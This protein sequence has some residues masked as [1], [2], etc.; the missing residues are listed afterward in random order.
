MSDHDPL[1]EFNDE[2]LSA[3][4]DDE[5]TR[6]ER[7]RVEERLAVDPAARQMLDQLRAVSQAVKDLPQESVG[8]DL[9]EAILQRATLASADAKAELRETVPEAERPRLT[10]G[11]TAR[12]WVWAGLAVAAALL[13]MIYQPGS[14]DKADLPHGGVAMRAERGLGE[15]E[16][17]LEF[18]DAGEPRG[19]REEAAA[20][21]ADSLA[22]ARSA[23][24][25][26]EPATAPPS[27][28]SASMESLA[29]ADSSAVTDE[30]SRRADSAEL[31]ARS[32]SAELGGTGAEAVA[33]AESMAARLP[34]AIDE[35]QLL[36]VHV[37]VTPVALRSKA[38]DGL[39]ARNGIVLEKPPAVDDRAVS[40]AEM[41]AEK[42]RV[43]VPEEQPAEGPQAQL[44]AVLVDAPVEQVESCL[45]EL[46]ADNENYLAVAVE[47]QSATTQTLAD[48]QSLPMAWQKYNRGNVS[49]QQLVQLE[50]G[51]VGGQVKSGKFYFGFDGRYQRDAQSELAAQ[52]GQARGKSQLGRAMRVQVDQQE[53]AGDSL[54]NE[55][56]KPTASRSIS[57]GNETAGLKFQVRG[58]QAMP[59][60]QNGNM[61][62]VLFVLVADAEPTTSPS[63][64][65]GFKMDER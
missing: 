46:D 27:A 30:V 34:E 47:D 54:A 38:F 36:V 14:Q 24:M 53:Y 7:V 3:Y 60:D 50:P 18:G 17:G 65:E 22:S 9:R 23:E 12:G 40:A 33:E 21:S 55:L 43:S 48:K 19:R 8:E 42:D 26:R 10:I 31:L 4:L 51:G 13:I 28:P 35:E 15:G 16:E 6:K 52:S 57:S 32:R 2:L 37:Q 62:Q 39:L 58:G 5:L 49:Q 20:T 63:G 11:R 61:V 1:P 64:D 41:M 59:A 25:R 44:D 29:A 45:D 56:N